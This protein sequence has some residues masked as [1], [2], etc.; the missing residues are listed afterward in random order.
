M[1]KKQAIDLINA[2]SGGEKLNYRNTH[3]S[4]IVEYGKDL[5]W[6]LNIPFYKFQEGF[7]MIL[8]DIQNGKI[9]F[10]K[11]PSNTIY[12][13]EDKFRNKENTADIFIS[14]SDKASLTDIQ[15]NSTG[16]KFNKFIVTEYSWN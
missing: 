9:I 16:F 1:N 4:D 7:Y 6:W 10:L 15:S 11:I 2:K 13:P 8:N 5:G 14:Y 12:N 3:W